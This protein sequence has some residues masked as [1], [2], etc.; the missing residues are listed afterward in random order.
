MRLWHVCPDAWWCLW[1]AEQCVV[2]LWFQS[3]GEDWFDW[4]RWCDVCILNLPFYPL[5]SFST[6]QLPACLLMTLT[7]EEI[8]RM[9]PC[10]WSYLMGFELLF[11]DIGDGQCILSISSNN[12]VSAI[13][14]LLLLSIFFKFYGEWIFA[15][16]IQSY[17]SIKLKLQLFFDR[18]LKLQLNNI[19]CKFWPLT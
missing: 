19:F 7:T 13:Q 1:V 15:C 14:T 9:L 2:C 6:H 17:C 12:N 16:F 18:K 10:V 4:F 11:L 3:L 5:D 8:R